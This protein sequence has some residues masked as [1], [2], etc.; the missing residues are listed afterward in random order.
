[1]AFDDDANGYIDYDEFLRQI[2]P[3]E[4]VKDTGR[5]SSSFGI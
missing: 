3:E 4:Y 5:M 1:M 2:F